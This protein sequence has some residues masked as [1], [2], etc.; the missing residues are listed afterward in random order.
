MKKMYLFALLLLAGCSG[1]VENKIIK[2][3]DYDFEAKPHGVS[4]ELVS[5]IPYDMP[6]FSAM[7]RG[8]AISSIYLEKEIDKHP[9]EYGPSSLDGGLSVWSSVWENNQYRVQRTY[10][11]NRKEIIVR[12]IITKK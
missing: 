4:T 2:S 8:N 1:K 11:H 6:N 10:G 5:I 12:Y 9:E 7:I 3:Y